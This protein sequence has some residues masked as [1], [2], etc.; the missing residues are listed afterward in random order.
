MSVSTPPVQRAK[1]PCRNYIAGHCRFGDSC[2]FNHDVD[3]AQLATPPSTAPQT[4]KRTKR[5]AAQAQPLSN[6]SIDEATAGSSST[7]PTEQKARPKRGEVPCFAWKAG[8]CAK[9]AKCWYGHDPEVQATAHRRREAV[10]A[11]RERRERRIE[12]AARELRLAQ[13]EL[14]RDL[15][16]ARVA[17]ERAAR[18]AEEHRLEQVRVY[19]EQLRERFALEAREEAA[20]TIQRVVLGSVITYSAGLAVRAVI[21]GFESCTVRVRGLPLDAREHE[22]RGLFTQQG[23]DPDQILVDSVKRTQD[24]KLEA[25]I[26]THADYGEVLAIGLDAVEFRDERLTFEV[27]VC[28]AAGGMGTSTAREM[29]VLTISWRAPSVRYVGICATMDAARNKVLE[30][31]GRVFQGR[32]LKVEINSP[33][34][35]HVIRNFNPNSVKISNLPAKVL[36]DNLRDFTGLFDLQLLRGKVTITDFDCGVQKLREHLQRYN[37]TVFDRPVMAVNNDGI[38]TIRVHFA[39]HQDAQNAHDS[40]H[41]RKLYYLNNVTPWLRLPTPHAWTLTLPFLQYEAQRRLWNELAGSIKDKKACYMTIQE[42]QARNTTHIRVLGSVKPAVGAL[43]V[44]VENLAAGEKVEGWHP[45][46]AKADNA[47]SRSVFTDTGAYMRGDWTRRQ[48]K[49]YG[50]SKAVEAASDMIRH[51][52]ERLAALDRI[53]HIP[54]LSVGFF[55]RQGLAELQAILGDENIKFDPAARTITVSGGEE[56]R[57]T[58]NRLIAQSRTGSLPAASG[59]QQSCPICFDDVIAPVRLGCNH[60]Y[61]T[62]CLRHYLLSALDSDTFPLVCMSDE[63]RCEA[64][65]ALSTIQRFHHPNAFTRLLEIAFISYVTKRPQELVYC[66]TPDCSQIY[67]PTGSASPSV[68]QCPSCFSSI[69]SGCNEDSHDGMSC[70]EYRIQKDPEAQDRASEEWIRQQ[71]SRIKRCP[72]CNIHI[73]KTEGCNHMS[74]R[75][76]A[77]ICWI[78]M[79]LFTRETIY[80]HMGNRHGGIYTEEPDAQPFDPFRNVD[81]AEQEEVLRQAQM[82]RAAPGVAHR[83]REVAPNLFAVQPAFLGIAAERAMLAQVARERERRVAVQRAADEEAARR[84]R[85]ETRRANDNGG[86]WCIVM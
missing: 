75:C 49:V 47:F 21:T 13:E 37:L 12:E 79:G 1:P 16:Q 69:C 7:Q 19:E 18:Q 23:I 31:D 56:A 25:N 3:L 44:R 67:R 2:R 30:L 77:H 22:I 34:P 72:Q 73:E 28:N 66:K 33:P 80:Q 58:L 43:K 8:S 32:R 9:G 60:V 54:K 53:V 29:N 4:H 26:V 83:H 62:A 52:L 64:P 36:L 5:N 76:G 45:A 35:G 38:A 6:R 68:L 84:R 86:G 11:E 17:E 42:S 48:L 59:E 57:H 10:Q 15:E 82:A 65:I 50:D 71:G 27:G 63:G 78:C 85:N 61:C 46:L 39:T 41:G 70:D 24:G 81:Y 55:V 74:C 20:K 51:E 40:L 14:E